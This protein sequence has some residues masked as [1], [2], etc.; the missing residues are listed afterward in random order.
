MH[1]KDFLDKTIARLGLNKKDIE[2]AKTVNDLDW[3][4]TIKE[5]SPAGFERLCN[6]GN[7]NSYSPLC[8][9]HYD[10]LYAR[11]KFNRRTYTDDEG[12]LRFRAKMTVIFTKR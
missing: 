11:G 7:A 6:L 9:W 12:K 3:V 10:R 1:E 8:D 5:S 2:R 4:I